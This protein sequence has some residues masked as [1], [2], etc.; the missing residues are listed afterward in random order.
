MNLKISGF[1]FAGFLFC[2]TGFNQSG[3]DNMVPFIKAGYGYLNDELMIDGDVLWSD[4]GIKLA[5]SYTFSLNFKFSETINDK[6]YFEY[7]GI[8]SAVFICTSK[9]LTLFMGYDFRSKNNRH[10]FLP[11]TGPFYMIEHCERFAGDEDHN[12]IIVKD[13]SQ[14]TG[15]AFALGYLYHFGKGISI[16]VNASFYL[17]YIMGP[18]YYTVSPVI[19][20]QLK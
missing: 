3:N 6:G 4:I 5:N 9:I 1:L 13:S 17:A 14:D 19:S 8:K 7:L 16:G 10:S 15:V 12:L 18:L 11:Q 20:F 2:T